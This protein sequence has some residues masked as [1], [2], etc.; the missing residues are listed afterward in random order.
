MS[1]VSAPLSL[2]QLKEKQLVWSGRHSGLR[3]QACIPSGYRLLDQALD[4]GWP[5]SG[6][7]DIETKCFGVGELRLLLP[8]LESLAQMRPL[9]AWL[10]MPARL[11]PFP[12]RP[13]NIERSLLIHAED[14]K[15]HWALEQL[16][17]SR[18]CSAV[19]FWSKGIS[20]AQAKRLQVV[21]LESQTLVFMIRTAE[22]QISLPLSLRMRLEAME[23][24]LQLNIFKRQHAW[25][26]SPFVLDMPLPY[27]KSMVEPELIEGGD[28][29]LRFP[30]LS[31]MSL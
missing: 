3:Q 16:L 23:E 8:A 27:P 1:S 25:P 29:I 21:A 10:G 17:A 14:K 26:L 6:V 28:N 11:A 7:V 2:Q 4:G 12:F 18:C 24:G 31:E 30:S 22:A 9:Q 19:V 20:P 13:A 15:Q 5:R